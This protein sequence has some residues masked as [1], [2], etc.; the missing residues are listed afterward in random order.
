MNAPSTGYIL[1]DLG[2]TLMYARD[3]WEPILSRAD[4]ALADALLVHHIELDTQVFRARLHQYYEQRDQN[5]E[6]TTY[7]FVLR[8]L[9]RDLGYAAAAESVVRSALD[10]LY[11]IT[12]R[13]WLLEEDVTA[14]LQKLKSENYRLGIFSNAGD[15]QD[16]Q[17]LVGKFGIRPYFDFVL[18]SAACYYR[19]PHPRAFEIALAQWS[20]PPKDAVMV[21]DSLQADIAGAQQS[22]IK[23]VWITRRAKFTADEKQRVQPDFEISQVDELLPVLKSIATTGI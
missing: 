20:I 22:G 8:E 17:E 14:T 23:T 10:A 2:G 19:K 4:R 15:D 7:H 11:T 13:N 1:F 16:V 21:G 5:C 12:Q 3:D 6:E 18:T 9:L